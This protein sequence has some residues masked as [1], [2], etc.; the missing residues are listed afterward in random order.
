MTEIVSFVFSSSHEAADGGTKPAVMPEPVRI[1]DAFAVV[2]LKQYK[3]ALR[4][5]FD[6]NRETFVQDRVNEKRDETLALYVRRLRDQS[7][8]SIKVDPSYI[9]EARADGGTSESDDEDE[10]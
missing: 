2:E 8:D 7:K 3:Q 1:A 10:Y 6:K 5:D 9:Q 4:A